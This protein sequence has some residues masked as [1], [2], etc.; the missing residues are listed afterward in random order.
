MSNPWPGRGLNRKVT[1]IV[2]IIIMII[3]MPLFIQ[4]NLFF[5][6]TL[7]HN[8]KEAPMCFA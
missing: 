1:K 2:T 4:G 6:V 8:V 3:I 7:F 5:R